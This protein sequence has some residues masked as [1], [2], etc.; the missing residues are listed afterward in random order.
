V[1]ALAVTGALLELGA[2][3]ATER[4]LG[5]PYHQGPAGRLARLAER[6][7]ERLQQQE[8]LA[9]TG[10][11]PEGSRDPPDERGFAASASIII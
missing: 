10:K 2:A 6:E 11:I 1:Q 4:R 7:R 9:T 8:R 3:Q 5:E